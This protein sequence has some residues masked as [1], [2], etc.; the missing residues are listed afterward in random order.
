MEVIVA[1]SLSADSRTFHEEAN[2][3]LIRH[4]DAAMHLHAFLS[5]ITYDL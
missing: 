4:T 5:G 2:I 1:V 3:E